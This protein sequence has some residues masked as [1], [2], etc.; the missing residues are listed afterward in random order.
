MNEFEQKPQRDDKPPTTPSVDDNNEKSKKKVF[1]KD[2]SV[3]DPLTDLL[4]SDKESSEDEDVKKD[5]RKVEITEETAK[6]SKSDDKQETKMKSLFDDVNDDDDYLTKT[7]TSSAQS[8]K[9]LMEDLFGSSRSKSSPDLRKKN[10]FDYEM[11]A[12]APMV[13]SSTRA[14]PRETTMTTS[15]RLS[16]EITSK[17]SSNNVGFSLS[18]GKEPRR[19]RRATPQNNDPLG[20][21]SAPLLVDDTL[22]IEEKPSVVKIVEPSIGEARKDEAGT[23]VNDDLPEWLGGPPKLTSDKEAKL[24]GLTDQSTTLLATSSS[25]LT[26]GSH[27]ND[28]A[29]S[30]LLGMEFDQRSA[31]V[32]MQQ[33][34][35]ELRTA[36]ALSQQSGKLNGLL[37]KQKAKLA[38]QESQFNALLARQC[39]RQATMEAQIRAQQERIDSY[40]GALASQP[41]AG[42][43]LPV[44]QELRRAKE[45]TRER[46]ECEAESQKL[47]LEK[48]YLES[49]LE[50]LKDKH[51]KETTMLEDSY[52]KQI[53]FLEE[54]MVQ[55]EK[56][57]MDDVECIEADY[58]LK[59]QK[60]KEEM[61]ELEADR[62]AERD[63]AKSEHAK[64]IAEMQDRHF[65][66]VE[67]LQ[68]EHLETIERLTRTKESERRAMN[69]MTQESTNVQ[70][71]LN[72]SQ[73]IVEGLEGMQKKFQSRD[74]RFDESRDHHYSMLEKNIESTRNLLS[75]GSDDKS[76]PRCQSV[77]Q[78]GETQV[79][80]KGSRTRR[81]SQRDPREG[82]PTRAESSRAS[83]VHAVGRGQEGRGSAG[84][85]AGP[86]HRGAL[87]GEARQAADT[88][89]H[90]HAE[91]EPNRHRETSVGQRKL[92]DR[93]E[94][95]YYVL[96]ERKTGKP[97][98][99][100]LKNVCASIKDQLRWKTHYNETLDAH[101]V[102]KPHFQSET[103]ILFIHNR[104]L[105]K[106]YSY[107]LLNVLIQIHMGRNNT[108]L[109]F[110]RTY[111]TDLD[112]LLGCASTRKNSTRRVRV[113]SSSSSRV[114]EVFRVLAFFSG[115][116]VFSGTRIFSSNR[117]F[118]VF[119]IYLS[120]N[121]SKASSARGDQDQQT[122]V[123]EAA[124]RRGQQRRLGQTIQDCHVTP[125]MPAGQ[126]AQLPSPGARRGGGS[127]SAGAE[128]AR[129]AT[130][131][132]SGGA[133]TG[134]HLGGTQRSSVEDKGALRARPG[135]HTQLGAQDRYCRTTRHLLADTAGKIL[136]RIIC[137]RL[138]AFTE[139]P[140]G[141]SERQY[142]FPERAINDRCHRGRRFPPPVRPSPARDG[143]RG[144]KKYCAVVTLDVRNA[145]NSARWGQHPRRST[146]FAR[147]RLL[148]ENNR[149]LLLGKSARLHHGRRSR[150]LRSHSRSFHRGQYWAR[151]CGT[152]C[153]TRS[154]A[155]TSMAMFVSSVSRTT[156]QWWL[157]PSI[158]GRSN[159]I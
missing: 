131:A 12:A 109:N 86:I 133:Y 118:R 123:L 14:I 40:I 45:T 120:F 119:A 150:V 19:G 151:S 97:Q 152:L 50:S 155:S 31:L 71:I 92:C 128:R 93:L 56:R 111:V 89:G 53:T 87:Q 81:A 154:C 136:E 104:H 36:L 138:E 82:G 147:T 90:S 112:V 17:G 7:T 88:G 5:E 122:S 57:M 13:S 125:R 157:S 37:A 55:M 72:K 46:D 130:A 20:L 94:I 153:M 25:V 132:S 80:G 8:K 23:V 96:R 139:R 33:Q 68:R 84:S 102:Y 24:S 15:S 103:Y 115:T 26:E 126:A 78:S 27:V 60:L 77:C 47:K 75:V 134:R 35:H 85:E 70:N 43:T 3:N 51:E 22:K 99:T 52:K 114:L 144:T 29:T 79:E 16:S 32:G 73:V 61:T 58:K 116:R 2:S 135:W 48:S 149:Q 64:L 34:E 59:I 10:M 67:L 76:R 30:K 98:S 124:L 127:V 145:F 159:T 62:K 146:P 156:S 74:E 142:G 42:L 54:Q 117:V 11:P 91:R 137:D 41:E 113:F 28:A 83:A 38:E 39:E 105:R 1:F 110:V 158:Y 66:N 4:L 148:A 101:D 100:S 9:L 121:T 108:F 49:T 63:R 129:P 140:G 107:E 141:L 44:D 95:V 18:A 69:T 106:K 65:K 21:L 6:L 143:Y